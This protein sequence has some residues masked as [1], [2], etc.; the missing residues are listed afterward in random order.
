ML[1]VLGVTGGNASVLSCVETLFLA[2]LSSFSN[3]KPFTTDFF[4]F[5]RQI[6]LELQN[7]RLLYLLKGA[8]RGR[9]RGK[10]ENFWGRGAKQNPHR[11]EI[12]DLQTRRSGVDV[13]SRE[14]LSGF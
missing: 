12:N 2:A 4:F 13:A 11:P 10:L 1:A 3:Y 8:E 9:N 7:P 14:P 6:P 5:F